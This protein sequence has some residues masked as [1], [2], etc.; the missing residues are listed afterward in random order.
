[1]TLKARRSLNRTFPVNTSSQSRLPILNLTE[2]S[3]Y[4]ISG[5]TATVRCVSIQPRI[6]VTVGRLFATIMNPATG[7]R[8]TI[9]YVPSQRD[10][11]CR[12]KI[13]NPAA[14]E[15]ATTKAK[16]ACI[17][18]FLTL[19]TAS[20]KA[21]VTTFTG[22]R[23]RIRHALRASPQFNLWQRNNCYAIPAKAVLTLQGKPI[24]ITDV[25]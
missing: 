6:N 15:I 11:D 24:F 13:F 10:F 1:M 20:D 17:K 8:S 21:N 3:D 2:S 14:L 16:G 18:R 22:K 23:K 4:A 19:I 5:S 25:P 12:S 9:L 7:A